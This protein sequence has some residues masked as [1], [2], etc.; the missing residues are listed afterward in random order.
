MRF[1]AA[2]KCR[3]FYQES[4]CDQLVALTNI[5]ACHEVEDLAC[6]HEEADTRMLAHAKSASAGYSSITIK[7]PDTDVFIIAL[8]ASLSIRADLYFETGR[9]DKRRIISISKVKE[10]LG[11]LWSAALIGFHSFTGNTFNFKFG[12]QLFSK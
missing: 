12:A 9:K 7:S 5:I 4:Q 3:S 8:N 10:N 2:P 11:D 6:D 1:T